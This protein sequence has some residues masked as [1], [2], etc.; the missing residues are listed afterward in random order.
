M[1]MR[2]LMVMVVE[3]VISGGGDDDHAL[4]GSGP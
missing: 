2:A 1:K 3:A 4:S